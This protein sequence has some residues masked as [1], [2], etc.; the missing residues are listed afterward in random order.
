MKMERVHGKRYKAR[1]WTLAAESVLQLPEGME[2]AE[3]R[4]MDPLGRLV[5]QW[6]VGS[7]S[8]IVEYQPAH[9]SGLYIAGLYLQGQLAG[10]IK[11]QVQR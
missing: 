3:L 2:H 9:G 5:G 1:A 4:V 10:H 8:P 6:R 7:G 11:F